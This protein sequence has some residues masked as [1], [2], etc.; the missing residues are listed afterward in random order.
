MKLVCMQMEKLY[1]RYGEGI[2]RAYVVAF[3]NEI[4]PLCFPKVFSEGCVKIL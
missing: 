4:I 3:Q 1:E 2:I